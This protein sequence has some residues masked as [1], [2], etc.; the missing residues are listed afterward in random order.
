LENIEDRLLRFQL[1]KALLLKAIFHMEG[2]VSMKEM[3]EAMEVGN[4]VG[5]IISNMANGNFLSPPPQ[6]QPQPQPKTEPKAE[7]P[8]IN[9]DDLS[10]QLNSQ[11][12]AL[13]GMLE[14]KQKEITHIYDS[15]GKMRAVVD[16]QIEVINSKTS[17]IGTMISTFQNDMYKIFTGKD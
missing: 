1:K 17:E 15:Y 13:T 2:T 12:Q 10:N 7:E 8:T 16:S 5:E 9:N 11:I 6:P 3:E 14:Q 4:R